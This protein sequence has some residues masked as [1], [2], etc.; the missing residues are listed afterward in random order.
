TNMAGSFMGTIAGV[1]A[2]ILPK[3]ML[4]KAQNMELEGAHAD[5]IWSKTGFARGADNRWKFEL[6]DKS[7][8]LNSSAFE[9]TPASKKALEKKVEGP[10]GWSEVGGSDESA[11]H[12]LVTKDVNPKLKDVFNHPKLYEAYP[13]IG[14]VSVTKVP[15]MQL[16]AGVKGYY[17]PTTKQLA[18]APGPLEQT[19]SII[20]HEV[21]HIVQSIEGFST[22]ANMQVLETPAWKQLSKAFQDNKKEIEDI[23]KEYFPQ[24]PKMVQDLRFALANVE[25]LPH[26][27]E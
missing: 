19:R 15:A 9:M 3:D 10:K 11:W 18:V 6:N 26:A 4:Y 24:N 20:L 12:Q 22:G 5:D 25:H 13:E 27:E 8:D 2:K 17:D 14:D 1:K 21:Q 23:V 7:A 16:L